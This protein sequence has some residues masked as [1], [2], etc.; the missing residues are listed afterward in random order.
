MNSGGASNVGDYSEQHILDC[1]Y[2]GVLNNGC[3]GAAPHGYA[4]Y[5]SDKKPNLSSETA[6]PYKGVQQSCPSSYTTFFQGESFVLLCYTTFYLKIEINILLHA[7]SSY[8]S[9]VLIQYNTMKS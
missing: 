6:F 7:S 8:F 1:G 3:N 5:L 2:D 4:K 9:R